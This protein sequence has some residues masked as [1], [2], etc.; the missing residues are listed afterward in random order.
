MRKKNSIAEFASQRSECLLRNFRESLARQSRISINRAFRDAIEAPAPRFWV[1]EARATL[2]ITQLLKGIDMT[3]G[4]QSQKRRMYLEILKR[5]KERRI[6]EPDTPVGD[7]VFEIVNS[8]AP[9]SYLTIDRAYRII[10]KA[11]KS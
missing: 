1:T 4:M 10:K 5:V 9:S 8:E 6:L 2:I 11:R 3:E 7:I